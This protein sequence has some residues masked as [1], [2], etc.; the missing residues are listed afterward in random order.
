[1]L[2]MANICPESGHAGIFCTK[3]QTGKNVEIFLFPQSTPM[4]EGLFWNQYRNF[5]Q[6]GGTPSHAQTK[7]F[8]E[9]TVTLVLK[10]LKD[11]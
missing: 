5:L 3:I 2:A 7:P 9:A 1:M 8:A 10:I 4:L 11:I 6:A